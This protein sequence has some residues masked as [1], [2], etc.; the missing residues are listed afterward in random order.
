MVDM[1][2]FGKLL[3]LDKIN[4]TILKKIFLSFIVIVLASGTN[5]AQFPN[6]SKPSYFNDDEERRIDIV[7]TTIEVDD[8]LI[9]SFTQQN[10]GFGVAKVGF[11]GRAIW[12]TNY[13]SPQYY[14]P[15]TFEIQLWDD[16]YLYGISTG[17]GG[18]YNTTPNLAT[19]WKINPKTGAVIWARDHESTR[20]ESLD[21]AEV[22]SNKFAMIFYKDTTLSR[23][24]A[25]ISTFSK[26]DGAE[27]QTR[28]LS[29]TGWYEEMMLEADKA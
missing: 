21:I 12:A 28:K 11:D 9:Y 4:P 14:F 13:Q 5:M 23:K 17:A 10:R 24:Q 26:S 16:G 22:D 18:A 6:F 3:S 15:S 19:I 1:R 2:T 7:L 29:T 20:T 27:V 8:G 25:F